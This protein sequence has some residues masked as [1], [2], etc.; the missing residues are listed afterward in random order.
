MAAKWEE[1]LDSKKETP[2]CSKWSATDDINLTKLT[3]QQITLA[4]PAL[5]RH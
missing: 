5:G 1:V 4:D 3:S 2:I